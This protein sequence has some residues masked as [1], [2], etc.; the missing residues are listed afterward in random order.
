MTNTLFTPLQMGQLTLPNRIAMAPMTRGRATNPELIPTDSMVE[1]Y[2]LRAAAGLIV[3]EG[4]WPNREAIGFV[5]V[6]GIYNAEQAAG[7]RKVTDAVHAEGGH[8]FLQLGH[9]GA[10]SH[11]DHLG[12]ALPVAPSA[13]NPEQ[14]TFR[15]AGFAATV[16]PREMTLD[17]IR[18]TVADYAK[19]AA[20][21]HDAGF[22]GVEIHAGYLYLIPQFL[23]TATNKRT[24]QYG[25]TAENRIR[26]AMEIVD[27][28]TEVWGDHRVGFRTSPGLTAGLLS[29]NEDTDETYSLLLRKLDGYKLAFLHAWHFDAEPG[30]IAAQFSDITGY[31]RK[32]YTGIVMANGGYTKDKATAELAVG[33]ADIV[34]FGSPWLA[35][36]DLVRRFREGF[37]LNAP[38][39][40]YFYMGGDTGYLDYPLYGV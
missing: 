19:A 24:D 3:T 8:I 16:T 2:R 1:Y 11:P 32:H 17:D 22:D 37:P 6:P 27:A 7:W 21:A 33:K 35:N 4:A 18:R 30:T 31:V 36:P 9:T 23:H 26:F 12:G 5:N 28:V 20:F 25:G 34:S 39:P 40:D 14:Q 15:P 10:L 38:N 29:A 13:V